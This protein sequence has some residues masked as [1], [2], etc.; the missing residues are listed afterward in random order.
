MQRLPFLLVEYY[1]DQGDEIQFKNNQWNEEPEEPSSSLLDFHATS[2]IV[3][4]TVVLPVQN[5]DIETE[6]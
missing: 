4:N 1:K 6:K 2:E 3:V 5:Y